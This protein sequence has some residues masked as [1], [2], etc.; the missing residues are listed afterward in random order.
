MAFVSLE[1]ADHAVVPAAGALGLPRALLRGGV[2]EGT[3][4]AAAAVHALQRCGEDDHRDRS[5]RAEWSAP[6]RRHRLA[7]NLGLVGG[8][9]RR[10]PPGDYGKERVVF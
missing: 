10:Q 6:F 7:G 1:P 9:W 3:A 4:T 5:R 8:C 2:A